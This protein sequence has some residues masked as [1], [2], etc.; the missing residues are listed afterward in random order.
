MYK[1]PLQVLYIIWLEAF[2]YLRGLA[3]FVA[4]W[5]SNRRQPLFQISRLAALKTFCQGYGPSAATLYS[6]KETENRWDFLSDVARLCKG[7]NIDADYARLVNDKLAFTDFMAPALRTPRNLAYLVE[8]RLYPLPLSGGSTECPREIFNFLKHMLSHGQAVCLR[9]RSHFQ[10]ARTSIISW[11]Q[12]R[13]FH[14]NGQFLDD[15]DLRRRLER[16]DHY[17]ITE[18]VGQADYAKTIFP[19]AVNT[20]RILTLINPDDNRPFLAG[21]L[22]NFGLSTS[23]PVDN[24]GQG[25]CLARI[26][27]EKGIISHCF[28]ALDQQRVPCQ[29]HPETR[30]QLLGQP[31]PHFQAIV[32]SL[33]KEHQRINYIKAIAWKLAPQNDGFILLSGEVNPELRDWQAFQALLTSPLT[34]RFY[35]QHKVISS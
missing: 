3:K 11:A 19:G 4:L 32:W 16:L 29:V 6:F 14:L 8:G 25:G 31:I 18:A 22:H 34:R 12:N 17:L 21:A 9:P 20:I 5:W 30:V 23:A 2:R 15:Q 27:P 35:D 26:D 13:G 33:L 1:P 7:V 10:G 28:R 24:L